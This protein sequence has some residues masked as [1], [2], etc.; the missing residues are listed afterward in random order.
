MVEYEDGIKLVLFV[1]AMQN[2][3]VVT[4]GDEFGSMVLDNLEL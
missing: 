2:L 4:E 1:F 3:G